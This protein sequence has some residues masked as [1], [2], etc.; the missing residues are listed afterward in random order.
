MSSLIYK[1]FDRLNHHLTKTMSAFCS[2]KFNFQLRERHS[3]T[4]NFLKFCWDYLFGLML[5]KVSSILV[6]GTPFI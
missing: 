1:T 3:L 2:F 5:N 4:V 6:G